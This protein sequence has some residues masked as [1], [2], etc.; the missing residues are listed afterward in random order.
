MVTRLSDRQP[1]GVCLGKLCHGACACHFDSD[2]LRI[3]NVIVGPS[4]S[5]SPTWFWNEPTR[6]V[7]SSWV[8]ADSDYSM[9]RP[10]IVGRLASASPHPCLKRAKTELGEV[11]LSSYCSFPQLFLRGR[12]TV[13]VK[14]GGHSAGFKQFEAHPW[15]FGPCI[16]S[17]WARRNTGHAS[18]SASDFPHLP[19]LS[20]PALDSWIEDPRVEDP[21]SVGS[22]DL[23]HS[24]MQDFIVAE[25]TPGVSSATPL[26]S[27]GGVST[28]HRAT[29]SIHRATP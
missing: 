26:T 21:T 8:A 20:N 15:R 3:I 14:G 13:S 6:H 29:N 24:L 2:R 17:H 1:V 25:H 16:Y 19:P 12:R 5:F 22:F 7:S 9:V 27:V 4:S 23:C 18:L 28:D 11:R 10:T